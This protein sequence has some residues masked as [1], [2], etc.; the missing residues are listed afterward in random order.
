MNT[1]FPVEPVYPPGF[2]YLPDFITAAEETEL[3]KA[4]LETELHPF[5]FHGY[6]GK[7]K[8]ASFGY[9]WSFEKQQLSKGKEIP[10][11]FQGIIEKVAKQT[12]INKE[13]FAEL[14]I[15]EYPVG[16]VINWHRDA[17]PFD[18]IAGL[19][20]MADCVFRLRPHDKANQNRSTT[21]S[22]SVKPRSLYIIQGPVRTDWQHST[23]P[24]KQVRY[25]ITLRTLKSQVT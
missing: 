4:I 6:T 2:V 9:D 7:R 24:V 16:A 14:L 15:T 10:S 22:F 17:P 1:L 3:M 13:A 12:G 5:N 20:L 8:V 21:L 23:A 19:S 11:V 18:T 25:S